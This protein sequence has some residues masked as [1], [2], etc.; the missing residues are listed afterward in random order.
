MFVSPFAAAAAKPAGVTNLLGLTNSEV[1]ILLLV[2][3]SGALGGALNSAYKFAI[4]KGLGQ[5]N[6][7]WIWWYVMHPVFGMVLGLLMGLLLQAGL[8]ILAPQAGEPSAPPLNPAGMA[9]IAGLTGMFA[10]KGIAKLDELFDTILKAPK[11]QDAMEART[12]V[13]DKLDPAEKLQGDPNAEIVVI[14]RFLDPKAIVK[15]NGTACD[16]K[17]DGEGRL[18]IALPPEVLRQT[19]TVFVSVVNPGDAGMESKPV[20]LEVK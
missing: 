18:K 7:N 13:I 20:P 9:A 4:H 12:P 19:G 3:V 11:V 1:I 15:V 17:A 8:L 10:R 14:G 2:A 5:F 16:V 6:Q